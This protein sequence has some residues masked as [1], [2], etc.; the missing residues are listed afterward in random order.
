LTSGDS[1]TAVG[2]H[3]MGANTT[4]GSNVGIGSDSLL[5]ATTATGNVAV[6]ERSLPATTT[7]GNNVAVGTGAMLGNTTGNNNVA[8]G[9]GALEASTTHRFNVAIGTSAMSGAEPG[10][11][12]TAIGHFVMVN[13]QG[14]QNAAMGRQAL[15]TNTTGGDNTAIGHAALYTNATSSDNTA[16]GASALYANTGEKNTAVGHDALKANIGGNN[17]TAIGMGAGDA[18]TT[19]GVNTFVGLYAGAY[20]TT[21][22]TGNRQ[23]IV[24][25]YSH[26]SAVGSNDAHGL[27]YD[28]ICADDYTTLGNGGTDIR[29]AHGNVTWATVS[30]ERYKKDI[31]DSTAGLSF[32]NALKPRTFKYKNLG[33]L[34]S[35]F[36]SYTAD[37]TV[38]F[39][40]SDTNH[41]FIA[42]E[43]KAAIDA[44]SS[45][46]NGFRLWDD[47]PDGSQEVAEAA[48]IP[49]LVKAI[50]EL[51]TKVD[52]LTLHSS[53]LE[54]EAGYHLD[55]LILDGTNGSS[56]NAGD[57]ILLG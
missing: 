7:G 22:T 52:T 6:G 42:Q 56:A 53:V 11:S 57:D 54:Q 41:G 55:N 20:T 19:G 31:V 13:N 3:A 51:S 37:S 48:L 14:T 30:D 40:N 26:A 43:V 9:G 5:L 29:A 39:K 1:N 15:F 18:V 36:N 28:L 45:I 50:Q 4:G 2:M 35:A 49:V 8:I 38:V 27:G 33:E 23:V 46:E 47:R 32:I 17:N 12:N 10:D 34:P 16:V 24:G 21:T 44:D 25:A